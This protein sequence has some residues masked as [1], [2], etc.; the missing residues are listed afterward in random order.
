MGLL[1]FLVQVVSP[2]DKV[3]GG[4]ND[5][6]ENPGNRWDC[7]EIGGGSFLPR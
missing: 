5:W 2:V 4:K 1:G 3:E 6:E 7:L